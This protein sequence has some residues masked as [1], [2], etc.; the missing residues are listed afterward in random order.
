MVEGRRGESLVYRSGEFLDCSQINLFLKDNNF[1]ITKGGSINFKESSTNNM[2]LESI[3]L[4]AH[5]KTQYN[6]HLRTTFC[7][8]CFLLLYYTNIFFDKPFF[9]Y[10]LLIPNC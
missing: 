8:Q 2:F 1:Q 3:T 5:E 7:D 6:Y 10:G 4:F 9:R